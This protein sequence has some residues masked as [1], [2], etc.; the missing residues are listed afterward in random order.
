MIRS[1]I[2]IFSVFIFTDSYCQV[3]T[4]DSLNPN[5]YYKYPLPFPEGPRKN[6][7]DSSGFVN[8]RLFS[9]IIGVGPGILTF[10]GDVSDKK[11]L[12]PSLSRLAYNLS[13][14]EYISR[15]FLISARALFGT[16][17]ANE[18]GPR[19]INF[20]SKIRSG[21]V[22]IS[23][24]FDNF[25]PRKRRISPFI[26]SGFEYFEFLSKTDMYDGTGAKYYYWSDGSIKNVDEADTSLAPSAITLT[27]DHTYE[28][29]IRKMNS[30]LF[31]KYPERSFAVPVGAGVNFHLAP[32]WNFKLGATMH[33]TFTD[34]IDGVTP[35]N[36]GKGKGDSKKDNFLETYFT[37][38][39]DLFNPKPPYITPLSDEELLAIANEDTDGDGVID[40]KDSCAG[41]PPGVTVDAKGC[42][43]DS[44]GDGVFDYADKEPNSPAGAF[45]DKDG[46][47]MD[48]STIALNYR[49]WSDSIG[50]YADWDTIVGAVAYA[51]DGWDKKRDATIVYRKELTVLIGKYKEGVPPDE[52]GKL[53]SVPDVKNSL[54]PDSTTAYTAGSYGSKT[55]AEKRRDELIASGFP[56][57]KVM[58]RNKD[59]SLSEVTAE[60]LAGINEKSDGY[61]SAV[62]M[63][64][65][66]F[67]VQLGAYSKKLS[68]SVFK[69]AG[70][71]VE[72]K[73]EDGLYKYTS[74]SHSTIQDAIKNRD[75]LV[76]RGY[77]GAF[78][79]AY[80]DGK[81]VPLS[82]VS[83]GIIQK[84]ESMDEP[85]T[86]MSAVD[87]SLV[88]FR[89]Q[90]G[91]FVNEPPADVMA[92][93]KK[94]PGLE[95]KKKSSGVTQYL[96]G[97][98][99][100]YEEAK[101]FRD[102]LSSKYGITD[103]FMVAF[104]KEDPITV[105]EAVEL[106]K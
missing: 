25:L 82:T 52:M 69:N 45:I 103:A 2:L 47:A 49:I 42:P 78:V 65:V 33:F 77:K 63:K 8:T 76:K 86:P 75:E 57:A 66:V 106:L 38:T 98:F 18:N 41:T 10:Y 71:L 94:V 92:K 20:E 7:G 89:L 13:V 55:N 31:G 73:T 96:A 83:G 12:A 24:N 9:P 81:R 30:K 1:C 46:V 88:S 50:Q 43:A 29:D 80:K 102:E 28:T 74:G 101:K 23:Y 58:I 4:V 37:L 68:T 99:N 104:F 87:K 56:N 19:F 100:N 14:S 90:V 70:K 54:Q 97:K 105:Q 39:F 95:T 44:D 3:I 5:A 21:G 59:G 15:S 51:G 61:T 48:D 79:V 62:D 11:F 34:Y 27:R 91:A 40:F 22:H 16:V 72:M 53:L 84:P 36:K 6:I 35:E 32:R 26:L 93:L 67:R 85:K 60:G 17:A 64:G